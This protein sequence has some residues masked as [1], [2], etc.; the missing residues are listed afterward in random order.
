MTAPRDAAGAA[1]RGKRGEPVL[2]AQCELL[3]GT[4]GDKPHAEEG[5]VELVDVAH[6]RC[7]LVDGGRDRGVV[8]GA[9]GVH[10]R[11]GDRRRK[12]APQLHRAGAALLERRV[13][14]EGVRVR[15]DQLVGQRAGLD[16]VARHDRDLAALEALDHVAQALDVHRL[17]EAVADGLEH[18][19]VI[20]DLAVARDVL[21]ARLGLREHDRQVSAARIFTSAVGSSSRR[22]GAAR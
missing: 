1:A 7:D 14:E 3:A 12:P 21:G 20:R 19:R 6:D 18:E 8:E 22:G 13:V 16:G 10:G 15:V 2:R 17:D 9:Q 11:R 4:L 5:V